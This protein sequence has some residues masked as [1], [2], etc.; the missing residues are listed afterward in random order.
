MKRR[1]LIGG[2]VLL[3]LTAVAV[4]FL[5]WPLIPGPRL[6]I[7]THDP[8]ILQSNDPDDPYGTYIGNGYIATRIGPEGVGSRDGQ[9]LPCLM[10]GLY[11]GEAL[12]ALPNWSDFPLYDGKGRRFV[13]DKKAPYRQTLNM[14][15]GYVETELTLKAGRQRLK[16]KVTLFVLHPNAAKALDL[17]NDVG[18]IRYKLTPSIEGIIEASQWHSV[19]LDGWQNAQAEGKGGDFLF[20]STTGDGNQVSVMM[21]VTDENNN[22][23]GLGVRGNRDEPFVRTKYVEVW[24]RHKQ[25]GEKW[26][27]RYD[28][29]ARSA[30]FDKLFSAHKKAWHATWKSDIVIEGD[31]AAQQ[32]VRAMLFY[33]FCSA[34]PEWSIPPTGLSSG[35]WQ[36]HI[37]WDADIWMF[38]ALLLQHPELA[39][40]MVKYRLDKLP[41]Y[42]ENAKERGLQGRGGSVGERADGARDY[43][44][45]ALRRTARHS[46]CRHSRL[47]G[48][49]RFTQH[50]TL[51]TKLFGLHRRLLGLPGYL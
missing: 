48:R 41:G 24:Q 10:S 8:W 15:E 17:P 40:G 36:G 32:A 49:T 11:E 44:L 18:V 9:P 34:N 14:R 35:A 28:E 1:I 13:L 37:F 30:G 26:L 29:D 7:K 12:K 19:S 42:I 2:T 25:E 27:D 5:F 33:L 47:D 38:P 6:P 50:S 22:T 51:N 3:A 43:R 39:R 46:R 20:N 4:A 16:G 31:P 45:S 23:T 21:T